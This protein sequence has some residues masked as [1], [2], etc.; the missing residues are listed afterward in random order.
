MK[1]RFAQSACGLAFDIAPRVELRLD[2][3]TAVLQFDKQVNTMALASVISI[4][5]LLGLRFEPPRPQ[6]VRELRIQQ[7]LV[8]VA[9][10]TSFFRFPLSHNP[11]ALS[12]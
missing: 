6:E 10:S 1:R 3:D 4:D 8:G 11:A 5:L 2:G 7:G 12:A 9:N